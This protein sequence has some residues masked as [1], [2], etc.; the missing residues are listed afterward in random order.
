MRLVFIFWFI[1][2]RHSADFLLWQMFSV[3]LVTTDLPRSAVTDLAPLW[4]SAH[5]ISHPARRS[6]CEYLLSCSLSARSA[7]GLHL[8]ASFWT[9]AVSLVFEKKILLFLKKG[10]IYYLRRIYLVTEWEGETEMFH[11]GFTPLNMAAVRRAELVPKLGT[12]AFFCVSHL[13]R[14]AQHLG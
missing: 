14:R 6:P 10:F 8:F 4:G 5:K 3:S 2:F 7:H 11:R 13:S 1:D 9:Q 12:S